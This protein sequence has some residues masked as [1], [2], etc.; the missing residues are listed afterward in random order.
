MLYSFGSFF[1]KKA[2]SYDYLSTG[3][4]L[5]YIGL[6]A[7]LGIYAIC[8]QQILK[9]L[10]LTLAYA[11]KAV[12]VVWGIIWGRLFFGESISTGRMIGAG[13]VIIGI[14]LFAVSDNE[15]TDKDKENAS[16]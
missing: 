4:I 13:I 11:N 8:W 16:E 15:K 6:I 5:C 12:T 9:K 1:S 3:F 7:I 14:V 2:A 10:P